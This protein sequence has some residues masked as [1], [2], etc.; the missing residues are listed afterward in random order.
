[1]K[2]KLLLT[3]LLIPVFML[4]A[5]APFVQNLDITEDVKLEKNGSTGSIEEGYNVKTPQATDPVS[6][7]VEEPGEGLS[8]GDS[9]VYDSD[10]C[11]IDTDEC[12]TIKEDTEIPSSEDPDTEI[13]KQRLLKKEDGKEPD[14]KDR[15]DVS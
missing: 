12:R 11:D 5:L 9:M 4:T 15:A 7:P 14:Q 10:M 6:N 1:M 3:I 13:N 8:I 2:N